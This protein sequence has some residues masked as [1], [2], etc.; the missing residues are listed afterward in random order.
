MI[1]GSS[2]FGKREWELTP[3]GNEYQSSKGREGLPFSLMCYNVLAQELLHD[4]QYLYRDHSSQ[5]L[6]WEYRKQ[7]LLQEFDYHQPDVSCKALYQDCI[8]YT[9]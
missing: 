8:D 1:S 3:F 2:R 6:D 9:F 4:N 5:V 7:K